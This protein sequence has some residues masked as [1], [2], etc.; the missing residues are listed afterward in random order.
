[1]FIV[2]R[3]EWMN[4]YESPWSIFE[5]VSLANHISRTEILKTLGN[6]EVKKIKKILLTD[7]RRELIKLSGF[8]LNILKQYLGVDLSVLNKSV[9]STL[10]KPVEY[11]QEPISTWFPQ[12]LNWCPECIKGGYHSWLHQ[13]SLFHSCPIH[14]I[15]LLSLC[16]KCLNPI[17]F[18]VSDL[19]LSEPFTCMCGFKLADIG[20][21]PWSQ[22]KMKVE[23][24]DV[25]VSKWIA[26]GKRDD[27]NRL[28][29]SPLV[30]SIQHFT[31]ES[32]IQSK[33]FNV[34]VASTQD[35]SYRDE[36][37][38]DLYKQNCRCFRNIDHYV[39]KKFIKK[40]LK[41]ILMLQELRKN[42]NEEFPPICP[43][44]YA[45]VFWKQTLL[46][47]EHF[48][49]NLVISRRR[50]GITVATELIEHIIDDYKNRLFAHTNLSKY[51]NREMFHWVI[52]RVT[53]ELCLNYFYEWLK[54]AVEGAEQ[55]SVP[56]QDKLDIMLQN[57]IPRAILK[58]NSDVRQKQK[59]EIILPNVDRRINLNEFK[60]PLSTKTM[61]KL[62][63]KMN[64]FKPLSVAMR[65]YENPSD[66]NKRIESYVK[67]YVMKLRI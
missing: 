15:K 46:G 25:P 63:F 67:Q 65:I 49:N 59:I 23:I 5:K 36:F 17:P 19:A 41:C 22:W 33:F 10:L 57:S 24:A 55:I 51:D 4:E 64:S 50:P 27:S 2:W 1:M 12:L 28:L 44:A 8:D 53:S 54:I 11:Y 56:N 13:F 3:K 66:E 21:T 60:C 20:S 16:P 45:Y 9:I 7:S 62:L 39:R 31:L 30:S 61:K 58:H 26:Q 18:L 43:Y 48:Y 34:K 47:R 52:N 29:F 37:K 40:H 42:E 6:A 14:Q 32:K 35:Y 38:N